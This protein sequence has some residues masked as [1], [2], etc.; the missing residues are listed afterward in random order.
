MTTLLTHTATAR[1]THIDLLRGVAILL[2]LLLHFALAFGLGNSPVGDLLGKKLLGAILW[3]GNYGVTMF[4]VISGYLI[5]SNALARFGSLQAIDWRAFYV[6]RFARIFPSLLLALAI[7]V[8]L[9]CL[10][11]PFFNNSDDGH[12]F[13]A[14]FFVLAA[15]SVLTFWHNVLMANVGWFNY[16]LNVYWSLSVEEVFY[17]VFPLA[18]VALKSQRKIVALCCVFIALAPLYRYQNA[19]NELLFECGYLACFDAI[20]FGCL[21][22]LVAQRWRPLGRQGILVRVLA[23]IALVATYLWGIRGHE[24]YGF[25]CIAVL[26]AVLLIA[27]PQV[28]SIGKKLWLPTRVVGWLGRHSYE[29]YLFHIIVLATMRNITDRDNLSYA[30]RLPWLLVYLLASALAAALVSRYLGEPMNRWIRSRWTW[31]QGLA[32]SI[33]SPRGLVAENTRG[34]R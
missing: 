13:P 1:N 32:A 22:A 14:S 28:Q 21:A 25:T 12:V 31:G 9:G 29:L 23:S 18:C 27:T 11:V 26:T 15:G 19:G 17:L 4:F 10:D 16:C 2:V 34:G 20:A 3:N 24:S 6:M 33:P 5:T 7:I 30:M 8:P